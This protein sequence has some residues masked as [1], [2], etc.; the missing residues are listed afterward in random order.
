MQFIVFLFLFIAHVSAINNYEL[1]ATSL[2]TNEVFLIGKIN[3]NLKEISVTFNEV[4][5]KIDEWVLSVANNETKIEKFN[6]FNIDLK[7]IKGLINI[8]NE[9][10]NMFINSNNINSAKIVK[11]A[12]LPSP[13]LRRFSNP[14]EKSD[15]I[16][17]NTE[18]TKKLK[19]ELPDLIEGGKTVLENDN[20]DNFNE[21][22]LPSYAKKRGFFSKYWMFIVPIGVFLIVGSFG[23]AD[24]E[25]EEE[26]VELTGQ[27]KQNENSE[28]KKNQVN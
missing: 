7:E 22:V 18:G 19:E 26:D 6:Y 13:Q 9:D 25:N 17:E 11:P 15:I 20:E 23:S 5:S 27:S 2:K 21:V 1:F 8:D 28:E 16:I 24:D 12:L 14:S 4:P 10:F 3:H